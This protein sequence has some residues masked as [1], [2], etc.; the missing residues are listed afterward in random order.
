MANDQGQID[1]GDFQY[2]LF[3]ALALAW[4][5]GELIPHLHSGMPDLPG[6]LTGLALTSAGGYSAKK[7]V[8]QLTPRITSVVP[9]DVTRIDTDTIPSVDI[10]GANLIVPSAAGSE[11]LDP[12][13]VVG[14]LK[15][16]V[17][18]VTRTAGS[19]CLEVTLPAAVADDRALM[20]TVVRAD[21]VPAHGPAGAQGI[22]VTVHP[23][24]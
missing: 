6:L 2:V 24:A 19:D 11:E 18:K 10:Y 13:V 20:I 23:A 12:T 17:S 9:A 3:N 15:A 16:T 4:Y 22:P 14:S 1:L 5:L 21:G 8:G 7:L